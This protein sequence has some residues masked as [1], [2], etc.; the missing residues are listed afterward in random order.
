MASKRLGILVG[1]GPAPGINSVIGAATIEALHRGFEQVIGI[2]DGFR[3]LVLDS[4]NPEAHTRHLTEHDMQNIHFDGGSILRTSRHNLLD[5]R[6]IA[7][8]QRVAPDALKV[9]RCRDNLNRLGV[10]HLITIGG[11]DTALSARFLH[12]LPD[13]PLR[14]VHMPKTIDNDL[15]LPHDISTFGFSTARYV[16]TEV[17]KN[18]IRDSQTTGRWYLVDTMGRRAGWLTLAI[19]MSAGATLALIPEEFSDDSRLHHIVD[20]VEGAILKA[21]V[22]GRS[23]GVALLAEGLSYRLGDVTE[24]EALIGHKVPLDAAG[25]PRLSEFPF[26]EL[27]AKELRERARARGQKLEFV[28]L[29]LGYELRSADPT[30]FDLAYCRMLGYFGVQLLLDSKRSTTGVMVAIVNGMLHPIALS[31]ITDP[32]TNRIRIRTVDVDSDSYRVARAYMT[33]LELADLDDP[34]MLSKLAERAKMSPEAFRQRY[35][36]AASRIADGLPASSSPG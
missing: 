9:A 14:L 23:D 29:D 25:H 11:D 36:R 5:E 24:L 2:Y 3:W 31:E 30:P 12:D 16:G 10:T 18:L 33:R 35:L 7:N 34:T 26:R 6:T 19:G 22:F 13:Y 1:G 8:G 15:P 20:V 27:V 4:F 17:V 32:A 21:Q 28:T